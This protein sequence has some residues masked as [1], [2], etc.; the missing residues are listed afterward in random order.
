MHS[1]TEFSRLVAMIELAGQIDNILAGAG[2]TYQSLDLSRNA[3]KIIDNP[4][5]YIPRTDHRVR[6]AVV[7]LVKEWQELRAA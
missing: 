3:N 1:T 2:I 5:R 7:E 4:K 6:S